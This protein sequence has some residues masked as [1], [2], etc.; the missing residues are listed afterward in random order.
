MI[1]GVA[2]IGL[3]H[4]ADH[5]VLAGLE[6]VSLIEHGAGLVNDRDLID[7][8]MSSLRNA[9]GG[10]GFGGRA[11]NGL[12]EAVYVDQGDDCL[13]GFVGHNGLVAFDA[14]ELK[15]VNVNV[16]LVGRL[17]VTDRKVYG[18]SGIVGKIIFVL[19]PKEGAGEGLLIE[20]SHALD[21]GTG[22][23]VSLKLFGPGG[24][25]HL[26]IEGNGSGL[27]GNGERGSNKPVIG[28]GFENVPGNAGA[29]IRTGGSPVIVIPVGS[30][31]VIINE[32]ELVEFILRLK[33]IAPDQF[34]FCGVIR[35]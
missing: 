4:G 35:S 23:N 30:V 34:G 29:L 7:H 2:D 27:S 12:N 24:R 32:G 33:I 1:E 16:V 15:G 19:F 20:R 8:V 5:V 3:D 14:E 28:I 25:G 22:A 9:E 11:V 18:L 26:G 31:T 21:F 10:E 17:I 13:I 6:G